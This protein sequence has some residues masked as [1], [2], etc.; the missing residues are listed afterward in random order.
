LGP[1]A[2]TRVWLVL[3]G[4]TLYVD[5]NGNGD[6]TAKDKRVQVSK[7]NNKLFQAGTLT[8]ADGTAHTDFRVQCIGQGMALSMTVQGKHHYH[9][10]RRFDSDFQFAERKEDAPIVHFNGPLALGIQYARVV[11]GNG[12]HSL[13]LGASLGTP[14]LGRATFASTSAKNF[15]LAQ[16]VQGFIDIEFPNKVAG[17]EA[18]RVTS[19]LPPDN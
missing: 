7:D 16:G 5:R 15:K 18:I 11:R 1:Q 8:E 6:L 12:G 19:P 13:L 17:K 4:D 2:K 3:D 10:G 9:V 14:G